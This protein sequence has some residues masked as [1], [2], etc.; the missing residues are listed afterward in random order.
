MNIKRAYEALDK[1]SKAK[2]ADS[3]VTLLLEGQLG[4]EI[5]IE[6]LEKINEEVV[7]ALQCI[8]SRGR[9]DR[10]VLQRLETVLAVTVIL[11]EGWDMYCLW[12]ADDRV[13]REL[14]SR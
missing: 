5:R 9:S 10:R 4:R 2:A 6:R 12:V 1:H 8:N 14:L 11:A 7:E 13:P 3:F